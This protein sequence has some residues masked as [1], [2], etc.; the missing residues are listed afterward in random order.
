MLVLFSFLSSTLP[1]CFELL[2]I[3]F[4]KDSFNLRRDKMLSDA[5]S[6]KKYDIL[7][8]IFFLGYDHDEDDYY[9]HY[10]DKHHS[11]DSTNSRI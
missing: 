10:C 11:D 6:Y 5:V 1:S 8:S 2:F 7:D 3:V 4:A 9:D